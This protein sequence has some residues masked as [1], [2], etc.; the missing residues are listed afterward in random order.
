MQLSILFRSHRLARH[1]AS[2]FS[3]FG[4][5]GGL[6]MAHAASPMYC[7]F[8]MTLLDGKKALRSVKIIGER[9]PGSSCSVGSWKGRVTSTDNLKNLTMNCRFKSNTG[10]YTTDS[11][12]APVN[13]GEPCKIMSGST[14]IASGRGTTDPVGISDSYIIGTVSKDT[15]KK[16]KKLLAQ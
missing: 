4:I 13:L 2:L 6:Q 15:A 9:E 12:E 14:V 11:L 8:Q 1:L 3:F 10:D 16:L 5:V 7:A